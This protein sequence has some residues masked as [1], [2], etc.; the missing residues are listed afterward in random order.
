MPA[1]LLLYDQGRASR[2]DSVQIGIDNVADWAPHRLT[3][4]LLWRERLGFEQPSL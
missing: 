2:R 3:C 4:Q 1:E